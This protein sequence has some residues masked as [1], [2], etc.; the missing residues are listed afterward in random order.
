MS[1][2]SGVPVGQG[3]PVPG[4]KKPG[5]FCLKRTQRESAPN[6]SKGALGANLGK[7]DAG[8]GKREG[9]SGTR[10][11]GPVVVTDVLLSQGS[12]FQVRRAGEKA[13]LQPP[14]AA[15]VSGTET[16]T[17]DNNTVETKRARACT[18]SGS[19]LAVKLVEGPISELIPAEKKRGRPATTGE[20]VGLKEK[21]EKAQQES[22]EENLRRLEKEA[23][24]LLEKGRIHTMLDKRPANEVFRDASALHLL[25]VVRSS[26]LVDKVGR[27]LGA[28][29]LVAKRSRSL[30]GT[31]VSLLHQF[32]TTSEAATATLISRVAEL[33]ERGEEKP[34]MEREAEELREE[35]RGLL[36]ENTRLQGELQ[37]SKVS[38]IPTLTLFQNRPRREGRKPEQGKVRRDLDASMATAARTP[39]GGVRSLISQKPHLVW[40]WDGNRI[41]E[42]AGTHA[43]V[44]A[45]EVKERAKDH[46]RREGQ[47][48]AQQVPADRSRKKE[49]AKEKKKRRKAKAGFLKDREKELAQGG[50]VG[51]PAKKLEALGIE[52]GLG[53]ALRVEEKKEEAWSRVP[54]KKEKKKEK[55]GAKK[56]PTPPP[57]NQVGVQKGTKGAR[58]DLG[59]Q[60]SLRMTQA[61]NRDMLVEVL[62]LTAGAAADRLAEELRKLAAKK[63]PGFRIRR[64]VKIAALRLTGLDATTG[65]DEVAAAVALA[66]NARRRRFS[67]AR[68][69]GTSG[70]SEEDQMAKVRRVQSADLP[71]STLVEGETAGDPPLSPL[72][73]VDDFPSYPPEE[74]VLQVGTPERQSPS[75][76]EE[77]QEVIAIKAEAPSGET[78]AAQPQG[79]SQEGANL[80]RG[81]RAQDLWVHSI[82]ELGAGLRVATEPNWV[83]ISNECWFGSPDGSVTMVAD[84]AAGNPPCV[85]RE[86]GSSYVVVD[87]GP[88]TVGGVYLLHH[89]NKVG[90]DSPACIKGIL[91]KIGDLVRK[92]H[93][94]PVITA[95]N[96][97]AQSEEWGCS[98]RQRDPRGDFVIGW[99]AGLGRLLLNRGSTGTCI[100]PGGGSSVIDST[101][102]SL[103]AARMVSEWRME[104]ERLLS[105]W[106]P[107]TQSQRRDGDAT[108]AKEDYLAARVVLKKA[109]K[110][111][112]REA[113]KQLVSSLDD[114]PWGR[115]YKRTMGKIRPW[116]PMQTETI[117]TQALDGLLDAL[118]PRAQGGLQ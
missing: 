26:E 53:W 93:P 12:K 117:D 107:G 97:N 45:R 113:W 68:K 41:A 37:A 99:A 91:D 17:A 10:I 79:V 46:G 67:A 74:G 100:R 66:G 32:A 19:S 90:L 85:L 47:A 71:P 2:G 64:S 58:P 83:P 105:L 82:R 65:A 114:D 75:A 13:L 9:A 101:S 27:A 55:E 72:M 118:F 84:P 70:S 30:K 22:K 42:G 43:L 94:R 112:K 69:D 54:G 4:A 11:A 15:K 34:E 111:A 38:V 60:G 20:R 23:W 35:I 98:P 59:I 102:A 106:P 57:T 104:V 76:H 96:F 88:I 86:K 63:G 39:G 16:R 73:V 7:E 49:R 108:R 33:D 115:R 62:S 25:K 51:I 109:I 31:L 6:N 81:A 61:L 110:K 5:S 14:G 92:C 1:L 18:S 78:E 50:G 28:V 21:R 44:Q 116:A 89:R 80:G 24:S 3:T 40:G 36:A 103:S 8:T 29:K 77:A 52:A 56:I 87:W 95:G 48:Q